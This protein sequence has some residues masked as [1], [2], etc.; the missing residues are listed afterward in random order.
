VPYVS[1][2]D[3]AEAVYHVLRSAIR[4]RTGLSPGLRRVWRLRYGQ[5]GRTF[6]A[7]VGLMDERIEEPVLAILECEGSYLVCT[8]THGLSD[9]PPTCVA[10]SAIL[11]VEDF[12]P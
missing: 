3:I 2:P 4:R 7:T 5:A 10:A 1:G 8:R 9:H 12:E 11:E 6:T